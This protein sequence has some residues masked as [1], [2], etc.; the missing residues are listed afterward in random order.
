[1]LLR[2]T[3]ITSNNVQ[4]ALIRKLLKCLSKHA[5]I[6]NIVYISSAN[7]NIIQLVSD[8]TNIIDLTSDELFSTELLTN[9][10]IE[11]NCCRQRHC[12][13]SDKLSSREDCLLTKQTAFNR[14]IGGQTVQ[15]VSDKTNS[16]QKK[17]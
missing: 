11:A 7:R 9:W 5:M 15:L 3:I 2:Q 1:M 8:L 12:H 14:N 17:Q 10:P 13:L 16:C 6:R 4:L